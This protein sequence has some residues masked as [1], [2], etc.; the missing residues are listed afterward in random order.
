[1]PTHHKGVSFVPR[2]PLASGHP[3]WLPWTPPWGLPKSGHKGFMLQQVPHGVNLHNTRTQDQ[4]KRL[5]LTL[6]VDTRLS[7]LEKQL[8]GQQES[9]PDG[10][11]ISE[12]NA[13]IVVLNFAASEHPEQGPDEQNGNDH[14]GDGDQFWDFLEETQ[15]V[16]VPWKS[17]LTLTWQA[18][19][20]P[21]RLEARLW[22]EP[23]LTR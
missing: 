5:F 21:R 11:V 6:D 12:R 7:L 22:F 13:S 3:L 8:A 9:K 10:Q 19:Q 18:F 14:S 15:G 1:M 20:Y 23:N 2:K 17:G 16:K 4:F